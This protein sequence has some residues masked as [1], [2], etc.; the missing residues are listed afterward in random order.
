[1]ERSGALDP[2]DPGNVSEEGPAGLHDHSGPPSTAWRR[3]ALVEAVFW[4]HPLVWWLG[5]RLVEERE[6]AC[7]ERV[8]ELGNERRTYAESILKTS[9]FC[10]GFP[11][12][13]ISGVTG[14]DLKQR[15]IHVMTPRRARE[16]HLI[17]RI[18]LGAAAVLALGAPFSA[19]C[20]RFSQG[21]PGR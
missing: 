15:I 12:A 16:L 19:D 18:L 14:A 6:R 11:L 3:R 7:D 5:A 9:R 4:F 17:Q 10:A 21:T 13:C 20:C 1:M 2:R 8:P